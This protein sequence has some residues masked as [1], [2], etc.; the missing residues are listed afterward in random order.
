MNLVLIGALLLIQ[1]F[2]IIRA[3]QHAV[4]RPSTRSLNKVIEEFL[5][6][7]SK[8][9]KNQLTCFACDSTSK[10][11]DECNSKAID[12]TCSAA[13]TTNSKNAFQDV[14]FSCM[15]IH[16]FNY[17]SLKTVSIEK[18]CVQECKITQIGCVSINQHP[19]L[20]TCTYCCNQ[21]YCNMNITISNS[22]S[23]RISNQYLH[24]INGAALFRSD[25]ISIFLLFS[26][27]FC[28]S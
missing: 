8:L 25:L 1:I 16:T 14:Q 5:Q 17:S 13:A 21:D 9:D 28:C 15:T 3:S 18:K 6:F 7:E 20:K 11:N 23:T 10:S 4:T 26:L 27:F 24:E 22:E 2:S 12:Q 19:N